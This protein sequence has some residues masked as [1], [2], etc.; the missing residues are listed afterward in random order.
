MKKHRS[1]RGRPKKKQSKSTSNLNSAYDNNS[2]NTVPF[3]FS[4]Q[5]G[6]LDVKKPKT[7]IVYIKTT[8]MKLFKNLIGITK[9]MQ[10]IH[11]T[12]R[13]NYGI[14]F[15]YV[16]EKVLCILVKMLA[17][18][19]NIFD[20]KREIR[21]DLDP[22]YLHGIIK[23]F[24]DDSILTMEI[25]ND[26][27]LSEADSFVIHVEN[28]NKNSSDTS[29]IG[30]VE[31]TSTVIP[32]KQ[33]E[34]PVIIKMLSHDFQK[35]IKSVKGMSD[36][37]IEFIITGKK[38]LIKYKNCYSNNT[39]ELG[40]IDNQLQFVKS[41]DENTVII[42]KIDVVH[43][44]EL[45]KCASFSVMAKLYLGENDM[46]CIEYDFG[47]LGTIQIF[48]YKQETNIC[49]SDND[50]PDENKKHKKEKHKHGKRKHKHKHKHKSKNTDEDD[51]QNKKT[52]KNDSDDDKDSYKKDVE[53]NI[54]DMTKINNEET[55]L[56]EE[57][58]ITQD[59]KINDTTEPLIN[60]IGKKI[61]DI[62]LKIDAKCS[63]DITEV[64]QDIKNNIED[65]KINDAQTNE[66]KTNNKDVSIT[67]LVS[68]IKKEKDKSDSE[69]ESSDESKKTKKHKHKHKHKSS[70]KEPKKKSKSKE[71]KKE[72][73]KPKEKKSKSKSKKNESESESG[74][75]SSK[76]SSDSESGSGS[77]TSSETNSD[78]LFMNEYNDSDDQDNPEDV[79]QN[80]LSE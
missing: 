8:A 27:K 39:K 66:I 36:S 33:L 48:M 4:S 13:P 21:F 73:K 16:K 60:E 42:E 53:N 2:N 25:P 65:V 75:D 22:S 10:E 58:P 43:L 45:S 6:I 71:K 52:T 55:K 1:G 80:E 5:T 69:S 72:T 26:G 47:M 37:G 14:K 64:K 46:S 18:Q 68:N 50:N 15:E 34:Y 40:E 29:I 28:P 35:Y 44:I 23:N 12:I 17:S 57:L 20:V 41:I 78:E 24:T 74:S 67:G 32:E 30:I 9:K 62:N 79:D 70:K 11:V 51:N 3:T 63:N 54:K 19:F 31:D 76:H 7:S 59:K 49:E 56:K 38:M 61:P 77:D